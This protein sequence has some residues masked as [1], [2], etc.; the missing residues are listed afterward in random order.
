MHSAAHEQNHPDAAATGIKSIAIALRLASSS[1]AAMPNTLAAKRRRFEGNQMERTHSISPWSA[2]N[3]TE[4]EVGRVRRSSQLPQ[5]A[6][7][8]SE[9]NIEVAGARSLLGRWEEATEDRAL[10]SLA[11]SGLSPPAAPTRRVWVG[12]SVGRR[13]GRTKTE[14]TEI[15]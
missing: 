13:G 10:S 1:A 2:S 4:R 7:P 14:E 5:L 6:Q 12:S 3:P 11:S 15:K 8:G 9:Q